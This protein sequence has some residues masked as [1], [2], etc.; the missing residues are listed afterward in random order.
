MPRE[1][2]QRRVVGERPF[3][4][5]VVRQHFGG[6]D[7]FQ[8]LA[9]FR[10][11]RVLL[12]EEL[13]RRQI[14]KREGVAFRRAH[15]VVGRLVQ[16]PVFRHRAGRHDARNLAA[17]EPLGGFGVLDLV[18]ERR[19]QARADQLRQIRVDGV[20]RHAAHGQV[21]AM[22]QRRAQYGRG[23]HGVLAEHFVEIAQ[24]EHEYGPGGYL[25]LNGQILTHHRRQFVSH[26]ATP[27]RAGPPSAPGGRP[28]AKAPRRR[29]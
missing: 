10:V 9:E 3:V 25:A 2:V 14:Q 6:A 12:D 28:P 27:W 20:V 19:R 18:A 23:A 13:A 17:H 22:G 4:V 8:R 15:V 29:A 11:R 24:P 1:A 21:V 26:W 16:K 5:C 7:D